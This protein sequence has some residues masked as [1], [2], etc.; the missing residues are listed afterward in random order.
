MDLG[1]SIPDVYAHITLIGHL[2]PAGHHLPA[3]WPRPR[4]RP[5]KL[6]DD[7]PCHLPPSLSLSLHGEGVLVVHAELNSSIGQGMNN[8]RNRAIKRKSKGLRGEITTKI[9]I[10]GRAQIPLYRDSKV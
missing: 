7:L 5:P 9:C 6:L 2:Y 1:L 8:I 3:V 4:H 10:R